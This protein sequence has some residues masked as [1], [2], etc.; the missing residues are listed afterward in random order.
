MTSVLVPSP[1]L[2]PS[3]RRFSLE[4][5]HWLIDAGFFARGDRVELIEGEMLTLAPIGNRHLG[6]VNWLG[7]RLTLALGDRAT[8]QI[9]AGVVL[10][11]A[12]RPE[13]D[14][15]ILQFRADAYK[16]KMPDAADVRLL[17]E[18]ADTS[19]RFDRDVKLPLY[20]RAGIAE[21]WVVDVSKR[22]LLV[23]TEPTPDGYARMIEHRS[24]TVAPSAFDDVVIDVADLLA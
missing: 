16:G 17:I 3:P 9:Q 2:G 4:E 18:V 21:V 5:Y 14:L 19:I 10:Q 24:G 23:A 7:R 11:P 13:P 15:A 12:S 20:A 22:V 1:D 6:T 8:V